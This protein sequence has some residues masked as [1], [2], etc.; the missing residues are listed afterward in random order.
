MPANGIPG[1]R[2]QVVD[3]RAFP[4]ELTGFDFVVASDVLYEQ[5][6]ASLVASAP[7]RALAPA[8][9][10][11]LTDPGR[12]VARPFA[13]ECRRQR[14]DCQCI[15]LEEV[16]DGDWHC[17]VELFEIRHLVDVQVPGRRQP[18]AVRPMSDFLQVITLVG[19]RQVA[20]AIATRL[21][22]GRLAACVQTLGPVGSTY[23]W[24]GQ[25]ERSDEWMCVI[26][27]TAERFASV[28]TTIREL[29]PYDLPE[30]I[31]TPIVTGSPEY[32]AW[33]RAE[34]A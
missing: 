31:A 30:I 18:A 15:D 26:K 19:D 7:A 23:R 22:A 4:A 12:N 34:T 27:T 21:I 32:L 25:I 9:T 29:H 14:L 2:T 11:W 16:V 24:Q 5:A 28:E 13:A 10:A 3:W 17:V 33:I 20:D 1:I 6:N 8:G